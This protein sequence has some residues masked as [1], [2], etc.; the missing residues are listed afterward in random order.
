MLQSR[1][2]ESDWG[3]ILLWYE[4]AQWPWTSNLTSAHLSLL[5]KMKGACVLQSWCENGDCVEWM[6]VPRNPINRTEV[7][8][9][10][11]SLGFM[12]PWEAVSFKLL[13][14]W[15]TLRSTFH[16]VT[17]SYTS[18]THTPLCI[19]ICSQNFKGT[20][21]PLPSVVYCFIFYF[22]LIDFIVLD[23]FQVY[24]KHWAPAVSCH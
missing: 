7:E 10:F 17:Q 4:L 18:Y 19:N 6:S 8:W 2:G 1:A 20:H 16:R 13:R 12:R 23:Q 22:K 3:C 5:C 14:P 21:L 11:T 15:A 24:R 9:L